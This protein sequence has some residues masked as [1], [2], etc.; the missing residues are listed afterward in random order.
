MRNG[1]KTNTN[2]KNGLTSSLTVQINQVLKEYGL[3]VC[4][5]LCVSAGQCSCKPCLNSL[6]QTVNG[7]GTGTVPGV[8]GG[9][10]I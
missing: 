7:Y 8:C 2:T 5:Q 9:V 4:G 1:V 6:G 3:L 10:S